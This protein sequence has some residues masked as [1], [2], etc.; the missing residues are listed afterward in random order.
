MTYTDILF[1]F[2]MLVLT[3]YVSMALVCWLY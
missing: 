2:Y 3:V 1:N